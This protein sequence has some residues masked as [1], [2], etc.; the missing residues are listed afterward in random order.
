MG[1]LAAVQ[2][3]R[4]RLFVLLSAIGCLLAGVAIGM[5]DSTENIWCG[6]FIRA[7]L[8][9]GAF[10]VA[11]PTAKR[12]AAWAGFNPWWIPVIVACLLVVVRRPQVLVP[13][14]GACFAL[15]VV[16]PLL[17]SKSRR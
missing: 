16:M 14:A 5:F 8:V 7:G 10:W 4:N 1:E 2:L 3:R 17:T 11:M 15:I 12:P 13:L 6:S 9:M